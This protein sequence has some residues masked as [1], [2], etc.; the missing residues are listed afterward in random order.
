MKRLRLLTIVLPGLVSLAPLAAADTVAEYAQKFGE[1]AG[2]AAST[3]SGAPIEK[4]FAYFKAKYTADKGD[5]LAKSFGG[6]LLSQTCLY[7]KDNKKCTGA[8]NESMPLLEQAV[9]AT[10]S[11]PPP[12]KMAALRNRA[13]VYVSLPPFFNKQKVALKDSEDLVKLAAGGAPEPMKVELEILHARA[14]LKNEKKDEAR[15]VLKAVKDKAMAADPRQKA[16]FDKAAAEA[17]GV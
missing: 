16:L 12:L 2:E 5:V 14:L 7:T 11:S 17:G 1:F 13:E 4:G 9:R 10:K 15:K 3:Q 8:M 6:A